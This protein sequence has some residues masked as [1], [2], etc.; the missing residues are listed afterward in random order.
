M[1]HQ[2]IIFFDLETTGLNIRD[3]EIIQ[4]SAICG[5]KTFNAYTMPSGKVADDATKVTGLSVREGRL[6]LHE[7]P[8]ATVPLRQVFTS[9]LAYIRSFQVPVL[10]AAHNAKFF[11]WVILTRVLQQQ[12]PDV[13][14]QF[15]RMVPGYLDTLPL[16]KRVCPGLTSYSL[17]SL[18]NRFLGGAFGAHNAVEDARVLQELFYTWDPARSTYSEFITRV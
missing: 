3:C 4:L 6:Y 1:S 10:L 12:F 15:Q 17:S 7:T 18:V 8:V 13:W 2:C 9:F 14:P 5:D 11:D 16:S